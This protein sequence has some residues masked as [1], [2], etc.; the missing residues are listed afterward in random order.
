MLDLVIRILAPF[1]SLQ[2]PVVNS[3]QELD[4]ECLKLEVNKFRADSYRTSP[5]RSSAC[6]E[7]HLA[8]ASVEADVASVTVNAVGTSSASSSNVSGPFRS[9]M[10][11][12]F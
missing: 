3:L 7:P 11:S 10:P 2:L 5:R 12:I 6:V 9:G 8:W 4:D 1:Y